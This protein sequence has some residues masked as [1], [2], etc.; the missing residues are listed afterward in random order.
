[1]HVLE[2]EQLI[3]APLE[4]TFR[5]FQ[6]PRN[7]AMITPGRLNLKTVHLDGLP[8]RAGSRFEYRIRWLG[9]PV[10]WRTLIT[11]HEPGHRFVD[12]QTSGPYRSWRHEHAFEERGGQTMMRDRVEYD[13]PLGFLGTIA[14]RL[15]VARQLRYIFDYRAA[16]IR[17]MF[18]ARSKIQGQEE[19][20]P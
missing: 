13:L 2:R 1:M 6:D 7:L 8:V 10:R 3:P 15:L 12:V 20:R 5:F 17:E 19:S 16:R 4:E 14:H 11:E 18:T 9:V